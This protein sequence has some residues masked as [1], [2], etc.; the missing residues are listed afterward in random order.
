MMPLEQWLMLAQLLFVMF[1]TMSPQSPDEKAPPE[2]LESPRVMKVPRK[3]RERLR[4]DPFYQKYSNVGGLPIL[5]SSKVSD[6]GLLEAGYLIQQMLINRP[7]VLKTMVRNRVRFVVMAPTEMTTD[8]PEQRNMKPK[9]Y[10]DRRARGFGGRITSCGEENLL[11]FRRDRYYNEN[12]LIHEFSHAIHNYGLRRMEPTF[13]R[14]LRKVYD[15]AMKKGLWKD[16]YA[17]NNP[18]EYWAE[19]VQSY[20]DCNA[21]RGRGVHNGVDTR[22]KLEKHDPELYKLIDEAFKKP[23]WRYVRY[24]RRNQPKK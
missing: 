3:L 4:L 10:W 20:F 7:D 17:A 13:D 5:S 9:E 8:V 14:R 15:N 18:S 22:E 23:K 2:K 24:D 16:T 11:N 19:G 21:P 12:I 1:I 6:E